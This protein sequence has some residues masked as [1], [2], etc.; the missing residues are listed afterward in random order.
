MSE[1]RTTEPLIFCPRY[2]ISIKLTESLAAPL[3]AQTRKQIKHQ[4]AE[5]E[6]F[7]KREVALPNPKKA[8]AQARRT[9]EAE[10]AERLR[11]ERTAIAKWEAARA[12]LALKT[13][14]EERD[15][16]LSQLQNNLKTS[17]EQFRRRIDV[18]VDAF[19]VM[20]GDLT[21]NARR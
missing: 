5:K 8:I 11:T 10:I 7:A 13:E 17:N 15:T 2:N 20:Q 3:I 14:I 21:A 6:R 9:L 19:N 16:Q 12:R 18:I 1:R 4:L